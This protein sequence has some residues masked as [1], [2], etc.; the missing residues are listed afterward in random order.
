M[1]RVDPTLVETNQLVEIPEVEEGQ[2]EVPGWGGG[3]VNIPL[4][5]EQS[6]RGCSVEM[7]S[8]PDSVVS[9]LSREEEESVAVRDE[10]RCL[11]SPV[12]G[13]SSEFQRPVRKRRPRQVFTYQTLGEPSLQPHTA[14][15]AVTT[16][17]PLYLPPWPTSYHFPPPTSFAP[18]IQ[19]P[20]TPYTYTPP[21]LF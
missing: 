11:N 20:Y 16:L 18:Y 1:V 8:L 19:Y 3:H 5:E 13:T 21:S 2:V 12:T 9:E 6:G 15:N 4:D 17:A 10:E 7:Q 14:V